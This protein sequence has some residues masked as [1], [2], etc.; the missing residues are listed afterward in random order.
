M[1]SKRMDYIP[2]YGQSSLLGKKFPVFLM[3]TEDFNT[4]QTDNGRYSERDQSRPHVQ[5]LFL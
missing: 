3:E 1:F 4:P 2:P 5:I